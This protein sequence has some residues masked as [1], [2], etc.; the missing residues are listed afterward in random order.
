[1]KNTLIL[2]VVI[3]CQV[4]VGQ[5]DYSKYKPVEPL[6]DNG[7][8]A[9]FY[10]YLSK[11]IDL[12]KVQNEK[13]VIVAFVLGKDGKMN[14]IKVGFCTNLEA[15]KEI[16]SALGKASNWDVSNQKDKDHFICFKMKL[17]FSDKE[18]KG[19]T[20]TMWLKKDI[21]DIEITKN[22]FYQSE[23][24]SNNKQDDLYN[25]AGVEEKPEYP[26]G[27]QAFYKFVAKNYKLP[28]DKN[29]K[30]GKA[31]VSFVIEKDGTLTD[32]EVLEDPGFGT[33]EEVINMLKKCKKWKP[34]KQKGI[35]VRCSFTLPITF[36]GY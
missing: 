30:G 31:V 34:A 25:S 16:T 29:F 19:L 26:G 27:I 18:V 1:M 10:E 4:V 11:T 24:K 13:D 32:F 14:H 33:S 36:Q 15:E 21:E 22:E 5:E 6:Y 9:K 12:S 20:K 7:G 23:E 3:F 2:F 8:V 35:P 17:L 28:E